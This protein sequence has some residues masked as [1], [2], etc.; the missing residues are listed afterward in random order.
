M[1]LKTLVF[2]LLATDITATANSVTLLKPT[3][4]VSTKNLHKYTSIKPGD[5]F[6]CLDGSMQIPSEA[7][8]DDYCDCPDASDEPGTSACDN[9]VFTCINKDHIESSI[10]SSRVNDGVCDEICCDGSDEHSG[11]ITC[12][13][14]CIEKA[15]IDQEYK[16]VVEN[17]RRLGALVKLEYIQNSQLILDELQMELD[18]HYKKSQILQDEETHQNDYLTHLESLQ[19]MFTDAQKKKLH[20]EEACSIK[21]KSR[22]EWLDAIL[23]ATNLLELK[24]RDKDIDKILAVRDSIVSQQ[25]EEASVSEQSS[26]ISFKDHSDEIRD[27][28]QKI[29]DIK[30][31]LDNVNYQMQRI[32]KELDLDYGPEDVF[33]SLYRQCFEQNHMQYKYKLCFMED[34][35]QDRVNLGIFDSWGTGE[36]NTKY[37]EM[38]F[39][40]GEQCWNGP[41]RSTKVMFSCAQEN[42]ILN[43]QEPNKC[44][45]VIIATTPAVCEIRDVDR[46][47]F[48]QTQRNQPDAQTLN[49]QEKLEAE[50]NNDKEDQKNKDQSTDKWFERTEL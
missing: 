9:G 44:E 39:K 13:N 21:M 37:H 22:D 31:Q 8:N 10:P 15:K 17:T 18:E 45:Y 30:K 43:V 14:R 26:V 11:L 35:H 32:T 36:S 47:E 5:V 16:S 27:T 4:G 42:A 41:E 12:P 25:H 40:Q 34:V 20:D 49:E 6:S 3:I 24:Q 46:V 7:I 23:N 2:I 19:E 50:Q 33:V 38:N 1:K 29:L 28:N 48:A